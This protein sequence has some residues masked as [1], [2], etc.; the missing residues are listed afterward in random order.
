MRS[1]KNRADLLEWLWSALVSV[2]GAMTNDQHVAKA[3]VANEH[4]QAGHVGIQRTRFFARREM[5]GRSLRSDM[6][7]SIDPAPMRW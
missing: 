1:A 2:N 3:S 6:C 7:Q 4:M 5:H